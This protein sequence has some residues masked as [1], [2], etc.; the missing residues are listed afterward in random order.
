VEEALP[1]HSAAQ[2]RPEPRCEAHMQPAHERPQTALRTC[3]SQSHR[4]VVKAKEV[5]AQRCVVPHQGHLPSVRA[6]FAR[7]GRSSEVRHQPSPHRVDQ[8]LDGRTQGIFIA[9][10]R[11]PQADPTTPSQGQ[12]C[13]V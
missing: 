7:Q 11:L 12:R 4:G 10:A 3:P 1:T 6:E 5:L 9:R 13:V 8:R 2:R